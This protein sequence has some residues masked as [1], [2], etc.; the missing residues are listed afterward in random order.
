M[1]IYVEIIELCVFACWLKDC[2]DLNGRENDLNRDVSE[3]D[4]I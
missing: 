2:L 3:R 1:F 4:P